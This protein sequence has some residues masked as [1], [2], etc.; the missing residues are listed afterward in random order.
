MLSV[1]FGPS[2]GSEWVANA[3]RY[4]CPRTPPAAGASLSVRSEPP[5]PQRSWSQLNSPGLVG[6]GVWPRLSPGTS[7]GALPSTAVICISSTFNLRPTLMQ[8]EITLLRGRGRWEGGWEGGPLVL[9][10]SDHL[11]LSDIPE[12]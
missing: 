11:I 4:W 1:C 5:S 12:E 2:K 8:P 10:P 6:D 9:R 3:S 7:G